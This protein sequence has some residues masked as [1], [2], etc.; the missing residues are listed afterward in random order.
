MLTRP[1]STQRSCCHRSVPQI[2]YRWQSDKR[3]WCSLKQKLNA[4]HSHHLQASLK[5]SSVSR[6]NTVMQPTLMTTMR[7]SSTQRPT[8]MALSQ[9]ATSTPNPAT[10]LSGAHQ[11]YKREAMEPRL[12]PRRPQQR[13]ED[14]IDYQAPH[15]IQARHR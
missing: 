3:S 8:T 2:S 14:R 5:K 12:H 1:D 6:P 13:C 7:P 4:L 11:F 15:Y 10:C 9:S